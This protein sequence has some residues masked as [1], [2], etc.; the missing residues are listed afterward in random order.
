MYK[1]GEI[2]GSD[3]VQVLTLVRSL[4][5]RH[6]HV[7]SGRHAVP[8]CRRDRSKGYT[9]H[10]ARPATRARSAPLSAALPKGKTTHALQTGGKCCAGTCDAADASELAA[11]RYLSD[12]SA[13][14]SH[15]ARCGSQPGMLRCPALS[16]PSMVEQPFW[17]TAEA[18][19]LDQGTI[20]KI[21]ARHPVRRSQGY[22]SL[23]GLDGVRRS[24]RA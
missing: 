2:V 20:S 7:R 23:S 3:S 8:D 9:T 18:T 24:A 19:K 10:S 13:N 21:R 17:A 14:L 6:V 5:N 22:N 11:T 4:R 1:G 16:A 15:D 12:A